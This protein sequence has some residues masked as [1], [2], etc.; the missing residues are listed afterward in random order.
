MRLVCYALVMVTGVTRETGMMLTRH[1]WR[2]TDIQMGWYAGIINELTPS[3]GL[4]SHRLN[5]FIISFV[6]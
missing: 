3:T 2:H 5:L 1:T 4:R 6:T